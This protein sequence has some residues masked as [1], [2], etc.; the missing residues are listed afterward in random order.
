ME[1]HNN[2]LQLCTFNCRSVKSSVYEIH[3]LCTNYDLILLQEHW[4][5]P[6]ELDL[7]NS[8]HP[9]FLALGQSAVDM[10]QGVLIGR[11]YGG[12]AILY[13]KSLNKFITRIQSSDPRIMAVILQTK[14]GP[15]LI[16][17][18]YMPSD[19]GTVDCHEKFIATCAN[20]TALFAESNAIHLVVAGDFNCQRDTRFCDSFVSLLMTTI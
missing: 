4:L 16:V 20:I 12:T 15:V 9:D 10:S 11:P 7:L 6:N 3:N 5:L 8:I 18:V 17:C 13:K 14:I 1:L 2:N 19:Y